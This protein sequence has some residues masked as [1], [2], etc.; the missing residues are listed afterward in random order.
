[1]ALTFHSF[2]VMDAVRTNRYRLLH[3]LLKFHFGIRQRDLDHGLMQAV[4][5]GH[6]ESCDVLLRAGAC[7]NMRDS[8]ENT[9]LMVA[10]DLGILIFD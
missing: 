5:S 10:C 8:Y 7:A 9:P 1:M 3:I 2:S 6:V 4:K